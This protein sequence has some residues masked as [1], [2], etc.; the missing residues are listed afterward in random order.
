VIRRALPAAA[1]VAA[2]VTA[3][4]PL[5]VPETVAGHSAMSDRVRAV[6][7]QAAA[8]AGD[9]FPAWLPDLYL[10]HGS[11]LP[12]FYA[13]LGYWLVEALRAATGGVE[14]AFKLAYGAVWLVGAAGAAHAARRRFGEGAAVPAA[15]A[16]ALAP[17]TL[18][19]VY[20]RAGLAE[21]T[22]L[23]I[24]PWVLAAMARPG[25]AAAAGGAVAVAA[26]ALAHNLTALMAVAALAVLA[27]CSRREARAHGLRLLAWGLALSLFFWLPALLE[28]RHLW[29]ERS[30]TTGFFDYSRHFVAPWNL[31]PGR[32]SLS[33][34][35]GPSARLPF[36][37]G[38][39]LLAGAAAA[40][41][42]AA[43]RG[44]AAR[45]EAGGLAAAAAVALLL[46]TSLA[47]PLWRTLPLIHYV[48]FPFRFFLL[49]TVFAAPLVGYAVSRVPER[50]RALAA[51]AA[52]ALAL[53]V[54]RP[55]LEARY[56]RVDLPTG[57]AIPLLPGELERARSDPRLSS[58]ESYV[59]LA[60]MRVSP[61][62]GTAGDEFLPRTVT[63]LP[64]PVGGR[65]AP[66]A[67]V[68]AGDGV[69][70][71]AS[72]WGYPEVWAELAATAPGE[73]VLHQFWFPGWRV[74]VDGVARAARPEPG[75]GRIVVA[76]RPGDR[77]LRARFGPTPLRRAAQAA[78]GVAA[79]ALVAWTLAPWRRRQEA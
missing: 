60:R 65:D 30:L 22:A 33:F 56:F 49:A 19:D 44:A 59:T 2:L 29:S 36:R 14:L 48:Q 20:V 63:A 71:R 68:A 55:W 6:A 11:P 57:Q 23:A 58:V 39:L 38:E 31:L 8:A 46:T 75:R 67:A 53:V 40:A 76:V 4:L 21:T 17:Y 70:V 34:T 24:V 47:A 37:F 72:G 13:P 1:L 9:R 3:L 15:A 74:E 51:A 25:R 61:W 62:N 43:R 10:R 35:I 66:P 41:L 5:A 12:S 73:I 69:S 52:V 79:L 7:F 77:E 27:L 28:A 54:A 78:S 42:L 45:S 64:E 32:T 16:F 50:R 18:V 26:L